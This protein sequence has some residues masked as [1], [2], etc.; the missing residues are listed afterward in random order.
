MPGNDGPTKKAL[1]AGCGS[2]LSPPAPRRLKQE[3]HCHQLLGIESPAL[4]PT[5]LQ[6]GD[7]GL[8]SQRT[9]PY[10]CVTRRLIVNVHATWDVSSA[11]KKDG[12]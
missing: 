11:R 1:L 4:A 7:R 9:P 12:N 2:Q 8:P 3:V 5:A 6:S 10:T